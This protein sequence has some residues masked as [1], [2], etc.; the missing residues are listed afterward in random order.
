MFKIII[1]IYVNFGRTYCMGTA[2][3]KTPHKKLKTFLFSILTL[4]VIGAAVACGVVFAMI[5]SAPPLDVNQ[6]LTLNEP[7]QLYNDKNQF[8]DTVTT[9]EQR[10]VISFKD[11][12][13]NLKHAF[14]A[15][16]DERFYKHNGID[17]KRTAGAI[18]IDI[19]SKIKKTNEIQ[20]GSTITQQLI[21]NTVLTNEVTITRK[22]QEMYLAMKLEKSLS[23][24]QILE[25]YL[26]TIF[27]GGQ[28][29]GVEAAS[30]QYFNKNAKD[31]TLIECA[32]LAGVNQSP[33]VFY[34]FSAKSKKDPSLYLNRTKTVLN[35]MYDN[36][37]I[38]KNQLATAIKDIDGKKLVISKPK[39]NYNKMNYESFSL[40]A[41]NQVK[42]DLKTKYNYTDDQI[43]NLL[44]NGDL[45]IYTTM[46]QTM[47]DN[48]QKI[49]NSPNIV[50]I[51]SQKNGIV[52]PQAAAVIMDYHTGE[53]KTMIGGRGDQPA[54]SYNRA[55]STNFLRPT[56]SA[57][58]PLTVY[59]AAIDSKMA[60]AATVIEDSP[61]PP[62]I[63]ALYG[64]KSNPYNPKNSPDMYY[65]YVTLREGIMHSINV[66]AVKLE[67][68]IGLNTG[69][70]YGQKFG[71]TFDSDDKSAISAIALGQL[72]HG[73]TPLIMTAAYGVFGNGGNYTTPR[74][75]RKVVDRTGKTILQTTVEESRVLSPES[76][77][78][79]YD[80][81]KGPVSSGGTGPQANF[82]NM[83]VRGK[84][85]TSED[86]QNLWFCGLTPY[87]SGAVWI[88][89][90]DSSKVNGV[91]SST[92]AALWGSIMSSAH[93]NL[94]TKTIAE[95]ADIVSASVCL[96]SGKL[97]TDLCTKDPRGSRVYNE[98]F[99]Q[100]TVPTDTC[101][102]HTAININKL[103]GKI[104]T[105][106]TPAFLV[107]SKVFIKRDYVPTVN[108]LDEPYA[109]PTL[110]DDTPASIPIIKPVV[111]TT[112]TDGTTTG[113]DGTT[114]GG[115]GTT[116]TKP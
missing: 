47:Q 28:A 48:T 20:G 80:L 72:H 4:F 42:A 33:S 50:G 110:F 62:A 53:V 58:K 114:T 73:T 11:M 116:T 38:T 88:G 36:G 21:K 26:N 45:K 65:G 25:A 115:D 16:E 14:V 15:I 97:P 32:F 43:N 2:K 56:G 71:L 102:I 49:L 51:A 55:D 113:G 98:L 94:P 10:T 46:D 74:L 35:K 66:V 29:Y 78:I 12:P 96:D 103:T 63:G 93:G 107:A 30:Q 81:L 52:E 77:Y 101:D 41:I 90:D 76:A 109:I 19:M 6:M 13:D 69:I 105:K 70:T 37:Y 18:Y 100:G 27:L 1:F 108:L 40:P 106:N 39:T 7:S 112:P 84:T 82:G 75:Y 85:G 31:L 34:P 24:D 57:I 89:N 86:M 5:K 23:K 92:A 64:S 22:I 67:D 111:P 54:R 104:A 3:R 87:Y 61:V 60:T 9:N 68:K 99:I 59:G 91:Y 44:I 8:I 79:M 95:P 83:E 17:L